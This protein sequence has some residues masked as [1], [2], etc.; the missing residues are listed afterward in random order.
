MLE[1]EHGYTAGQDIHVAD[2]DSVWVTADNKIVTVATKDS[3]KHGT[4]RVSA[5][6]G[7]AL[8]CLK[9]RT[10]EFDLASKWTDRYDNLVTSL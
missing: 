9:Y 10:P 3:F 5:K 4:L 8:V 6:A 1:I 2:Q 7:D